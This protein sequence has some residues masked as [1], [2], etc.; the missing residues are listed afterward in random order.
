VYISLTGY[1]SKIKLVCT[2]P[3]KDRFIKSNN[4]RYPHSL[5]VWRML[6]DIFS[7]FFLG[8]AYGD[9][10][11]KNNNRIMIEMSHSDARSLV[12]FFRG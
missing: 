11:E 2:L 6:F 12:I 8:F 5:S 7:Y 4:I 1:L 9:D 3:V 10:R